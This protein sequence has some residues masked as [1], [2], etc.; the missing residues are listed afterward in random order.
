[1]CPSSR[2]INPSVS[3]VRRRLETVVQAFVEI[4]QTMCLWNG[5]EVSGRMFGI[6]LNNAIIS[7]HFINACFFQSHGPPDIH[8][9]IME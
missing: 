8:L 5:F 6:S 1:M 4:Q 7:I 3:M 9:V 2:W